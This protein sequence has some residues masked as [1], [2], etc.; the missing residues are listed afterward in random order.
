M[1]IEVIRMK[2]TTGHSRQWERGQTLLLFLLFMVVLF[3]FVGLGV[4]LG[5]AYITKAKLS[6]AVDAAALMAAANLSAGKDVA[7]TV[8]ANTFHA[9]YG[10]NSVDATAPVPQIKF[11]DANDNVLV[12]VSA[13]ATI[14]TFFIRVLP[15]IGGASWSTLTVGS[16]AQ[17]TR[18]KLIMPLVLDRSGSMGLNGGAAAMPDAVTSFINLFDDNRD[19]VALVTFASTAANDVPIEKHFKTDIINAVNQIYPNLVA[20]ATFSQEA[21]TNAL[22]QSQSV[23]VAPGDNVVRVTVFFTDGR[24]NSIQDTLG[25]LTPTLKDFG[26]HDDNIPYTGYYVWDPTIPEGSQQSTRPCGAG[27]F[28]HNPVPDNAPPTNCG[29]TNTQFRSNLNR[30]ALENLTQANI[31]AE[32]EFRS[33]QVADA[34]RANNT[35]VYAIGLGS[36]INIDFLEQ[37]ANVDGSRSGQRGLALIAPTAADIAST[38]QRVAN[39]ILLRLTK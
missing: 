30:G 3:A 39:D 19:H 23:P 24:A 28:L 6:K 13:T 31:T 38:F 4:D 11:S 22:V 21:L 15:T 29:C 5:F 12:D 34:M 36:D 16:S 10:V 2:S 9:N 27:G 20:G 7:R 33:E 26:G 37:I 1:T 17:A 25:C 18:A 8:A 32:A 14:N 35:I